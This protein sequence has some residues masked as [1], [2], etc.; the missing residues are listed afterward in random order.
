MKKAGSIGPEFERITKEGAVTPDLWMI[1]ATGQPV[2]PEA[3]LDATQKAW[4]TV[5]ARQ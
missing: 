1:N 3:L 4:A 2:G 5:V